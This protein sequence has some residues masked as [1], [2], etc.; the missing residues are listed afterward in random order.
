M[1]LTYSHP[2]AAEDF[3]D[4][5]KQDP[6]LEDYWED[7]WEDDYLI[8]HYPMPL[9]DEFIYSDPIYKYFPGVITYPRPVPAEDFADAPKQ[10]PLLEDHWEYYWE[11]DYLIDFYPIPLPDLWEDYWED[12]YLID[13]YPMPLPDGDIYSDPIYEYFPSDNGTVDRDL[14]INCR[15]LS[16]DPVPLSTSI[17]EPSNLL[18]YIILGG[19]I[20][21]GA[22]KSK[23]K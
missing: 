18:G 8:D 1:V 22:I 11:D 4:A 7:Y 20:L 5:P 3:A 10:D 23:G 21:G 16:S 17:P 6:L 15:T 2:V 9:L 19:V 14:C 12:D 13:H